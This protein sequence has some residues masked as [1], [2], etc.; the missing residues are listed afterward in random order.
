VA[1]PE[2]IP[3]V[4]LLAGPIPAGT[5]MVQL[6]A[7]ETPEIAAADWVTL[8][9]RFAEFMEGKT[10]AILPAESGGEAFVRLRATGFTDIDDATRFCAVLIA[11]GAR[12]V[13]VVM[14]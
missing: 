14:E 10:R 3:A 1:A 4:E 7:Y 11:E 2:A 12:C 6:G 5:A 8:S 9:Q 13:P